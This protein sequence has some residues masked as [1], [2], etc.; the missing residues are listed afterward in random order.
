MATDQDGEA[1]V[2]QDISPDRDAYVAGRDLHTHQTQVT[3]QV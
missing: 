3:F 1:P 2:Y